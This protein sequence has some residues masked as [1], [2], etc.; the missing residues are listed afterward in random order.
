MCLVVLCVE[1]SGERFEQFNRNL[2]PIRFEDHNFEN[3]GAKITTNH[4]DNTFITVA[5]KYSKTMNDKRK[6]MLTGSHF[7]AIK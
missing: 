4:T 7:M 6:P 5:V 1:R 3:F 2:M